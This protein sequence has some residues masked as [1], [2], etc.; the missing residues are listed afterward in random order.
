MSTLWCS[1]AGRAFCNSL[2]LQEVSPC[3][4][5]NTARWLLSTPNIEC[6]WLAKYIQTSDPIS[7]EDPVTSIFICLMFWLKFLYSIV[8][9]SKA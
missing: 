7:P 9:N 6:P 4:P 1:K 8:G 5:K 2:S 3:G